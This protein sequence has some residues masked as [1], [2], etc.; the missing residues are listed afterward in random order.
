MS[1]AIEKTAKE[2]AT[3]NPPAK[4][5]KKKRSILKFFKDARA[6]FKKV[7]WPTKKSVINNT[8]VVLVMI[9]VSALAVWGLDSLF[10][11]INKL[12]MGQV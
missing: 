5:A 11:F 4:P 1:K 7:V 9:V 10:L 3:K 12:L 6:E 2:K 8:I